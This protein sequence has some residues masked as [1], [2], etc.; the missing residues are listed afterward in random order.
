MT[1]FT[2]IWTKFNEKCVVAKEFSNHRSEADLFI[3]SDTI[4]NRDALWFIQGIILDL[5]AL[6]SYEEI[7]MR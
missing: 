2:N 1:F 5:K 4:L 6:L 3:N 7:T